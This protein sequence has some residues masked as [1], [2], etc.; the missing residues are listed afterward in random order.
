MISAVI[1][2]LKILP[3]YFDAVKSGKKTFEIRD[4]QDRGF[5]KGDVVLLKEFNPRENNFTGR[6]LRKVI[7]YVT[8][9]QQQPGF[10]VFSMNE[11]G[12]A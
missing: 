11:G 1:H 3:V 2:E 5:Q 6:H 8:N 10:V 7:T 9:Y 12:A 4:N